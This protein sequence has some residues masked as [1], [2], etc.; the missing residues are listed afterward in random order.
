MVGAP[1]HVSASHFLSECDEAKHIQSNI[2][3]YAH[4]YA[5][6]QNNKKQKPKKKSTERKKSTN[7]MSK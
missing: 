2:N 5:R 7:G 1:S 6:P 3:A 4:A